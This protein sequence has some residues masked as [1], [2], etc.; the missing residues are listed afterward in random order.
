MS[1]DDDAGDRPQLGRDR[2]LTRGPGGEA[3]WFGARLPEGPWHSEPDHLE[4]RSG[5]GLPCLIHRNHLGAWCGYV[6]VP[7]GH[8]WHGRDR[9]EL[10]DPYPEAHGGLTYSGR[11]RGEIC[12]VPEPGESD[13]VWWLGFDCNHWNDMSLVEVSMSAGGDGWPGGGI[14]RTAEYA[15]AETLSL[16]EQ[17][18][19]ASSA[20]SV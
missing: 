2:A 15:R 14:Y 7:P 1:A 12:H 19:A 16:A 13:D 17:A 18:A 9:N 3:L 11:C 20:T 6:G 5:G 10:P 8:P 4:F